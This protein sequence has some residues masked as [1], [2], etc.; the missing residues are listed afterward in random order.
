M[1]VIR[2]DKIKA[3]YYGERPV[4]MICVGGTKIWPSRK[5]LEVSPQYIWL[6]PGNNFT[7]DANVLSNTDWNVS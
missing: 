5:Y 6:M 1:S 3:C 4:K 2:A 7:D